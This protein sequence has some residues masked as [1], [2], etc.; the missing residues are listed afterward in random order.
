MTIDLQTAPRWLLW[1][2]GP[3][4]GPRVHVWSA[5]V[6]LALLG[7]ALARSRLTPLRTHDWILLGLGLLQLGLPEALLLPVAL[8]ALGKRSQQSEPGRAWLYDLG[9]LA[10][11]AL[12]I[13]AAVTLVAAV[14]KGLLQTPEMQVMGNGSSPNQL[15][16]YLDR[17]G[18]GLPRP[19]VLSLPMFA[20]RAAMLA[21]ALW[22]AL[23]C[24]RWARWIW[25]TFKQHGLWRPLRFR[26]KR[27]G[28]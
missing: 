24:V 8:L 22:L 17:V 2:A 15:N 19:A 7:L 1:L 27:A 23:A 16:W 18:G 6:V 12:L 26:V 28:K 25:A 5:L 14:E 20:Y 21:W 10:L 11:V 4:L 3:R 9:Q 13:V